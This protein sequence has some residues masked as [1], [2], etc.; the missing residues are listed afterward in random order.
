M[1]RDIF[2]DALLAG[3]FVPTVPDRRDA[4][5]RHA[6][7]RLPGAD[8]ETMLI[9][10]DRLGLSASSGAACSSGSL[11][12]SHVLLACGYS[13]K[14]AREGLRFSF[15]PDTSPADAEE[16]ARRVLAAAP[17]FGD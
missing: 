15:G 9:N 11:E 4:L 2:L 8:A 3:G 14:E 6:H 1:A 10:L 5:P 7:V 12:P 16:A 13:S 17:S